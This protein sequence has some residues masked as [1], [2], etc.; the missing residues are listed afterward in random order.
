MKKPNINEIQLHIRRSWG[1]FKPA[2][3]AFKSKRDYNRKN[4]SW[5]NFED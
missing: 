2:T 4:Q 3:K 1:Q 5:K